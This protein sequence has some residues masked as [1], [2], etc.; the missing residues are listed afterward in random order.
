MLPLAAGGQPTPAEHP[1]RIELPGK[2]AD[3]ALIQAMIGEAR[4]ISGQWPD[5]AM[6]VLGFALTRSR[7][8]DY[9]SGTIRALIE[10]GRIHFNTGAYD[11]SLITFREALYESGKS[12]EGRKKMPGILDIISTLYQVH[13]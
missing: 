9:H 10:T 4:E 8:A 6:A 1:Y 7:Q 11:Q 12:I 5:S 3:T 13:G 2:E